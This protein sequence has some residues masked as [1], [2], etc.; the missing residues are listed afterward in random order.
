MAMFQDQDGLLP[1][2]AGAAAGILSGYLVDSWQKAKP[3]NVLP[4]VVHTVAGVAALAGR[5]WGRSDWVHEV[6]EGVGYGAFSRLGT[7]IAANTKTLGGI[8]PMNP[9]MV[10]AKVTL[11]EAHAAAAQLAPL[12]PAAAPVQVA[13]AD[14][15]NAVAPSVPTDLGF[16]REI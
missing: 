16:E 12:A 9:P 10:T 4:T 1:T 8:K 13:V 11:A 3:G 7:F 15:V 6:L 14:Q 2:L 5:R